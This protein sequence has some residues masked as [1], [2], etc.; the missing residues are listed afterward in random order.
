MAHGPCLMALDLAILKV[1]GGQ[2]LRI[3]LS[4][5]PRNWTTAQVLATARMWTFVGAHRVEWRK[6]LNAVPG[7]L[8]R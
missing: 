2:A 7:W 8:K 4:K 5:T 1:P 3:Y 6:G